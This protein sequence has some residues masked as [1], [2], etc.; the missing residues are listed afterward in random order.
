[1]PRLDLKSN[2]RIRFR[3]ISA[4]LS[5]PCTNTETCTRLFGLPKTS[6]L[7]A[8]E[9]TPR[10]DSQVNIH[11][12]DAFFRLDD[13]CTKRSTK[14]VKIRASRNA[15][16]KHG[17]CCMSA[18]AEKS[19]TFYA[20]KVATKNTDIMQHLPNSWITTFLT[21]QKIQQKLRSSQ[22]TWRWSV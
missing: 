19:V 8:N 13:S 7:C 5:C 9:W 21:G 2:H 6:P 3:K 1:M 17:V 10:L 18:E 20:R 4:R 14:E 15:F 16:P 12:S 11:C 22:N